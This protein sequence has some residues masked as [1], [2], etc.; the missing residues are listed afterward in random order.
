MRRGKRGV[1]EEVASNLA[2][3]GVEVWEFTDPE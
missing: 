3:S 2:T 1:R